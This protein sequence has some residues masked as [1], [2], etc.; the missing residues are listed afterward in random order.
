MPDLL[1]CTNAPNLAR[2]APAVLLALEDVMDTLREV[3]GPRFRLL[4][5]R[6]KCAA[7]LAAIELAYQ[8][9]DE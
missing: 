8:P 5:G 3:D 4:I 1:T 2:A 9:V 7:A 6:E